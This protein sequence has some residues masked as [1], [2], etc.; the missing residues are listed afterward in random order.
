MSKKFYQL[1]L[2]ERLDF[3]RQASGMTEEDLQGYQTGGGMTPE[4]A[5]A[6][7]ENA[8]GVL[9][10]P[11]VSR[12]ILWLMDAPCWCRWPLKNLR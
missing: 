7:V 12:N 9:A 4:L 3:L 10:Y 11:W 5:D 6:M 8:I 1:D 2:A